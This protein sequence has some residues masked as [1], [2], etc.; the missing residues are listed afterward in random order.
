MAK[1]V[2]PRFDASLEQ[3]IIGVVK[4]A[5]AQEGDRYKASFAGG[6]SGLSFGALQNDVAANEKAE[7]TFEKILA[8]SGL[9][10]SEEIKEIMKSARKRGAKREDLAPFIDRIDRALSSEAGRR[11]IDARDED[12][13]K[14]LLGG[15]RTFLAAVWGEKGRRGPGV[16]D[17]PFS[18]PEFRQA[19]TL[20]A[21]WINRTGAPTK[22]IDF[23]KGEKVDSKWEKD[24]KKV[25]TERQLPP[26]GPITLKDFVDPHTGYFSG[27]LQF[28]KAGNGEDFGKWFTR[29]TKELPPLDLPT[30]T[31]GNGDDA[32]EAET[33]ALD[34]PSMID[35]PDTPATPINSGTD[36]PLGD[37]R[38]TEGRDADQDDFIAGGSG[39]DTLYGGS[40]EDRLKTKADRLIASDNYYRDQDKQAR[41]AAIFT[42]LYPPDAEPDT[43]AAATVEDSFGVAPADLDAETQETL[44]AEANALIASADYWR[45]PHK[46]RRVA[47]IF[48]RLYPGSIRTAPLDF[49]E[50]I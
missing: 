46:Q 49:G 19:V 31:G 6:K 13:K 45:D 26:T 35:I 8:H 14:T 18:D 38:A 28:S 10:S 12:Q 36:D 3:F 42:E 25:R 39:D 20:V 47:A 34:E 50:G 24:G 44:Q 43:A 30:T 5:E 17:R 15:M 29:I 32:P 33:E 7:K 22:I 11:V 2:L 23:V 16:F 40:G 9:F 37:A 1:D 21:A 48:K 41:V 27:R 4:K